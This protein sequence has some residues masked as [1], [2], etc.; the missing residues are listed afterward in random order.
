MLM[1]RLRAAHPDLAVWLE[2][3]EIVLRDRAGAVRVR[4]RLNNLERH[5]RNDPPECERTIAQVAKGM[6][7]DPSRRHEVA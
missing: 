1:A 2:A 4:Q 5:C 6:G 3:D 7:V